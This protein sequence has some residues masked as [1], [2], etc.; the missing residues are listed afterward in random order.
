M[1]PIFSELKRA[2][3]S[4]GISLSDVAES[5]RI[6]VHYLEAI[7]EGNTTILPRAYLRAIVREYAAVV[8]LKTDRLMQRLEEAMGTTLEGAAA[9]QNDGVARPPLSHGVGSPPPDHRLSRPIV[10]R[11]AVAALV[12][13]GVTIGTWNVL[14]QRTPPD[15]RELA[16]QKAGMI[17]P[18]P[19]RG[20][21][22]LP[23]L[24]DDDSLTLGAT[25]NDSVWIKIGRDALEPR[26]YF[27]RPHTKTF[28]RAEQM[29]WVSIGNAGGVE[30]TLNE[31]RLGVFGKRR[32]IIRDLLFTRQQLGEQ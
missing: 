3:E 8:G 12:A 6:K 11:V 1:K 21:P 22:S 18:S 13:C 9:S 7:E 31:R 28:W 27:L 23:I 15:E 30:F 26:Q 10:L 19:S 25:T 14:R 24:F 29:F 2:R 4:N 20:L 17:S 5:I 16:I 32:T